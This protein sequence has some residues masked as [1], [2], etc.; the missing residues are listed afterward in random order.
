MLPQS[1][2]ESIHMDMGNPFETYGIYCVGKTTGRL[3]WCR[4]LNF[5][6]LAVLGRLFGRFCAAFVNFGAARVFKMTSP[7]ALKSTQESTKHREA[8]QLHRRGA[9]MVTLTAPAHEN[10]TKRHKKNEAEY[11]PIPTT[12]ALA[13]PPR[14]MNSYMHSNFLNMAA[15][16][17]DCAITPERVKILPLVFPHR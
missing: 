4:K 2:P 3:E 9:K 6:L 11:P 17:A 7:F 13:R 8:T 14:T 16:A 5:C 1:V 12:T 10:D 15:L